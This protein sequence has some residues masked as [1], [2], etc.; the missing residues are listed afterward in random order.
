MIQ[1]NIN[2]PSGVYAKYDFDL[3]TLSHE[4]RMH[5]T[6]EPLDKNRASKLKVS[7]LYN[8]FVT[9][10]IILLNQWMANYFIQLLIKFL[11]R[12]VMFC[13]YFC[14]DDFIKFPQKLNWT[15]V[16][17]C[18]FAF[19]EPPV[20]FLYSAHEFPPKMNYERKFQAQERTFS[21]NMLIQ[22]AKLNIICLPV[23]LKTQRFGPL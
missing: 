9:H 5:F 7:I 16:S 4:K 10:P 18:K 8:E 12:K 17:S 20:I 22:S 21:V 14:K 6:V 1:F 13:N 11:E 23:Y 2:V 3:R 15:G 19:D